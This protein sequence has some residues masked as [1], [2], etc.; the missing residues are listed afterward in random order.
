MFW[1][2]APES[3]IT[4]GVFLFHNRN[5]MLE[6]FKGGL[7]EY[8][9]WIGSPQILSILSVTNLICKMDELR[10]EQR[11]ILGKAEMS[12]G[13]HEYEYERAVKWGGN[14]G[15][16]SLHHLDL[17]ELS[18]KMSGSAANLARIEMTLE[19]VSKLLR[20]ILE[21]V[22]RPEVADGP[23]MSFSQLSVKGVSERAGFLLSYGEYQLSDV[24]YL[25]KRVQIQL[26]AVSNPCSSQLSTH[27]CR[28][29]I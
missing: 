27:L 11:E 14:V 29:S 28:F 18:V 9:S 20:T 2:Y 5:I 16:K 4:R 24:R 15:R 22:V 8:Q 23:V 21:P 26:T 3:A 12:S 25:Q 19:S 1:T 7:I 13:Y 10:I 6:I 17:G